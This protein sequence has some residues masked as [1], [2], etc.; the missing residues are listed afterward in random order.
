LH[1]LHQHQSGTHVDIQFA[2][3]NYMDEYKD[4]YQLITGWITRRG[5]Q[6][7]DLS[8]ELGLAAL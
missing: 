8:D 7:D 6:W 4:L 2:R 3:D 5:E 1:N